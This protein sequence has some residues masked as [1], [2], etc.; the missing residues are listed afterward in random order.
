MSTVLIIGTLVPEQIINY[1]HNN[2]VKNSA[3]DIAQTYMLHG[4]E[5]NANVEVI[6]TIGAVRVKPY[7]KTKI[8]RFND[9][10]Q[11]NIKGI[12]RGI[13]YINLPGIAFYM[14]EKAIVSCAKDWARK[15]ENKTDV[16]VLVY[17]MH[18][19]F[20]KAAKAVK[21]IIPTAKIVVTVADLPLYMDMKGGLRKVL[22]QVDWHRIKRLMK[23]VDKY[24]L[25]TK[26]MA[27]YLQLPNEKWMV[28]EGL[29]DAERA[30]DDLQEKEDGKI[31]IYAGNLDARYGIKM[32]VDAFDKIKSDA[33][34]HI[35]GAGF[36]KEYIEHL[37]QNKKNVQYKGVVTSD[38]MFRIMKGATLLINPRPST[39]GLAKYS[40]PSKTFEYM[41]SGTPV[42]MTHLPGL[43][44]EYV[45]YIFFPETEDTDGFAEAIDSIMQKDKAELET[46]GL[47]AAKFI[48]EEKNSECI[49]ENVMRFVEGN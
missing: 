33:V 2:G 35:Y 48:K 45:P 49:M 9:A 22:K 47:R 6:D 37:T 27:D 14:R 12:M 13:G 25:Y 31:C 46:F 10:V 20:M 29:F 41:A 16:T 4:L 21:K 5:K 38:E 7:P 15:N 11:E 17:S 42:L 40:C 28:F 24:L 44:D 3:A 34:L 32:L 30:V 39:I 19:P 18:S 1:C 36:D 8:K 26:Y 43:P 23:S